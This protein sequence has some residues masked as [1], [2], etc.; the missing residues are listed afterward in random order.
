MRKILAFTL[1]F[2]AGCGDS[3]VEQ[4]PVPDLAPPTAL[5]APLAEFQTSLTF[6]ID[7]LA[8]DDGSGIS[9]IQLLFRSPAGIWAEA[10]VFDG[11]PMTFTAA[12]GGEHAFKA[13]ATDLAGNVQDAD[14]AVVRT[15][16]VPEPI[17]ITDLTGEDFD[18]TNA[19]LRYHIN[20]NGWAHGF[21]RDR[22]PPITDPVFIHPG[23]PGYPDPENLADILAVDFGGEQRAYAIGDLV[24]R[25]VVDDTLAGVHLAATY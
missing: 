1:L 4:A 18:I 11:F 2:V 7:G 5:V 14:L 13:V 9:G 15:T 19:V 22:I 23:E 20:L 24:G 8:A 21:G 3:P 12:T 6:Q 16:I 17:I 25:E 10:G